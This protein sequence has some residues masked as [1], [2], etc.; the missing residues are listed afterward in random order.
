MELFMQVTVVVVAVLV[1]S[2]LIILPQFNELSN[3]ES[4]KKGNSSICFPNKN[5]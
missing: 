5:T 3:V 2:N 1:L 4:S